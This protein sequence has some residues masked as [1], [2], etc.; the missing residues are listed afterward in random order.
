MLSYLL[1]LEIS[2]AADQLTLAIMLSALR[3]CFLRSHDAA[4]FA[5]SS[6]PSKRHNVA[7]A[8]S[9]PR[10]LRN[11]T[12]H[13]TSNR[14]QWD[15]IVRVKAIPLEL[16]D[17]DP[18]CARCRSLYSERCG[19]NRWDSDTIG[20]FKVSFVP[21]ETPCHEA[22]SSIGQIS[23]QFIVNTANHPATSSV[24]VQI[25]PTVG[26]PAQQRNTRSRRNDVAQVPS[27]DTTFEAG[28]HVRA[29]S[30]HV[31]R[32]VRKAHTRILKDLGSTLDGAY[33]NTPISPRR[34]RTLAQ[35]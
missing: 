3:N 16:Y 20:G 17:V 29:P 2:A 14:V 30:E 25:V 33:W 22:R 1:I 23:E 28:A 8:T 7:D 12:S 6:A 21:E 34:R 24:S 15:G 27:S 4:R 10:I 26:K 19:C 11:G 9:A 5:V 32:Q 13:A 31:G 18:Q 35:I